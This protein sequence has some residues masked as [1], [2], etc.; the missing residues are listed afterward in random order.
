[1]VGRPLWVSKPAYTTVWSF[2][3]IHIPNNM[4]GC[5]FEGD[6]VREKVFHR[7][8]AEVQ[9]AHSLGPYDLA[10]PTELSVVHI[11]P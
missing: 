6:S 8:H 2:A 5:H 4:K 11:D 3:S 10:D 7:V 1:M 9:I